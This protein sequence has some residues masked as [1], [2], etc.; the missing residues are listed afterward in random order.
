MN[1]EYVPQDNYLLHDLVGLGIDVADTYG[2][3]SAVNQGQFLVIAIITDLPSSQAQRLL[4][5]I[6]QR[7]A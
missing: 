2:F 5:S 6:G 4:E 7:I 1:W 3:E